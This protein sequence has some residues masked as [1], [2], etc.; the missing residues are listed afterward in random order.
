MQICRTAVKSKWQTLTAAEDL[1]I[2]DKAF[3]LTI[4]VLA[5]TVTSAITMVLSSASVV[6]AEI[7]HDDLDFFEDILKAKN[8]GGGSQAIADTDCHHVISGF[9][10]NNI[11]ECN[12]LAAN[13]DIFQEKSTGEEPEPPEPEPQTC[14]ECFGLLD[15]D[16]FIIFLALLEDNDI[17]VGNFQMSSRE[18]I[19][20]LLLE[21][22]INLMDLEVAM[23]QAP[24][25]NQGVTQ[26]EI[27]RVIDCIERVLGL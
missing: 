21:G 3:N 15:P 6:H 14:T 8:D 2:G 4:F 9:S 20:R 23:S 19:C 18:E 13:G 1:K 16:H 7:N 17:N 26:E 25:A 10:D 5:A 11:Q 12:S 22:T 24:L 27:D